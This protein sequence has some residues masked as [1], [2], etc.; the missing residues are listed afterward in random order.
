MTMPTGRHRRTAG[1]HPLRLVTLLRRHLR[2]LGTGPLLAL[3]VG[4]SVAGA[5]ASPRLQDAAYDRAFG[6]QLKAAPAGMRDILLSYSNSGFGIFGV[7]VRDAGGEPKSPQDDIEKAARRLL[8]P[9]EDLV[10]RLTFSA[11]TA[12]NDVTDL[13][14][15]G[16]PV[17]RQATRQALIRIQSD[18]G[19]RVRWDAGSMPSVA[20]EPTTVP[21]I[22]DIEAETVVQRPVKVIPVA[23]AT[24]IASQ[25][26][27]EVG[28]RMLL[29]TAAKHTS[30]ERAEPVV[31]E[32]AGTFTPL[33]AADAFWGAENRM[34]R[35]AIIPAGGA[36]GGFFPQAVLVTVPEN[37]G[38]L[39]GSLAALPKHF[40]A[41]VA[42]DISASRWL[43]HE[44]RIVVK[45]AGTTRADGDVLVNAVSRMTLARSEWGPQIP[46]VTTGLAD[47]RAGYLRALAVTS[48]LL[49][50]VVVALVAAAALAAAQLAAGLVR[51]RAA[52]L[53]L[54]RSRGASLRQLW[55]LTLTETGLWVLPA[56]AL[57]AAAVWVLV[58]G[59]TR[60]DAIALAAL[61]VLDALVVAAAVTRSIAAAAVTTRSGAPSRAAQARRIVLELLVLA[62]A[63]FVVGTIRSRGD[64]IATG[65]GDWF[66]ALGP[67][68]LALAAA[69]ILLRVYP[70]LVRLAA[71]F[72]ARRRSVLGFIGLSR[73]ARERG[74]AL[75]PIV[76]LLVAAAVT[77]VLA[78][79]AASV[80]RE[81]L[82]GLYRAVGADG[83]I[84]ATRID[85][86]DVT[87]IGQRPGIAA[88]LPAY[89]RTGDAAGRAG[90][91]TRQVSL[92]A[93]G[94]QAYAAALAGSPL[95]FDAARL[96][97]AAGEDAIAALVSAKLDTSAD[98]SL[99][100][101]EG[102]VPVRIVGVEPA[103]E[104]GTPGRT[105]LP[106]MLVSLD[107]LRTRLTGV[108]PN[109]LLLRGDADAIHALA[110]GDPP[111]P[112]TEQVLDRR[113][114][115][116][117][118]AG[119][120][121]PALVRVA[122][123][124]ALG[125]AA[126]LSMIAALQVLAATRRD[127]ADVLI[128]LRTMGLRRGGEWRL[129]LVELLPLA[130]AAVAT[131]VGVG[132]YLPRLLRR[133][134]DLAPYTGG[135]AFPPVRPQG[136]WIVAIVAGL[137]L[138]VLVM[139][140]LDALL[141]RRAGLAEHL[142]SG[143]ER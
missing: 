137:L 46:R 93:T 31:V 101:D 91:G 80:D 48:A 126:A 55:T 24:S 20:T 100:I 111:T 129:G 5:L 49:Q 10:D 104:R 83:R 99:T 88:A 90:S 107:D 112:L 118:V 79:V 16:R 76:T 139:I 124:L 28:D 66:A 78:T 117:A 44:W 22:A 29:T 26:Q 50:F 62:L 72:V 39:G 74:A 123:L 73:S 9:A 87:A 69:V 132:L 98:I 7:P 135:P 102:T 121:L 32:L 45:D 35:P 120:A 18:L 37:Y 131:G 95:A 21:Y 17:P 113:A 96:R 58:T 34:L 106:V 127:R 64:R 12:E 1:V 140:I 108:Q 134:L 38:P 143:G 23:L 30:Y 133:V 136:S 130:A 115:Q 138:L 114:L 11:Q 65:T 119:R 60:L 27:L 53:R 47:V 81:R 2:R 70:P 97:P 142:R 63:V 86:R 68:V 36:S 85:A 89:S 116:A 25:W 122:S 141:A 103:L 82:T 75:L 13:D 8:G 105:A 125:L 67:V 61:P 54:L 71:Y 56:A 40:A 3:L 6:D 94:P 110:S 51:A 77:T 15:R 33:N 41:A 14:G 109:T 43:D 92:L 42:P 128:R 57:A 52:S 84:V 19:P 4:A 59:V